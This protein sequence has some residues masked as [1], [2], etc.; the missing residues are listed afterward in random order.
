MVFP[1]MVVPSVYTF[2]DTYGLIPPPRAGATVFFVFAPCVVMVFMSSLAVLP[3]VWTSSPL[4]L[5]VSGTLSMSSLT[6]AVLVPAPVLCILCVSLSKVL[7]IFYGESGVNGALARS[8]AV[9][10][11]G[12]SKV[13][14]KVFSWGPPPIVYRVTH[15]FALSDGSD[16]NFAWVLIKIGEASPVSL[17]PDS[18]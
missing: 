3:V 2:V 11:P 1:S 18:S 6:A 4:T 5:E 8:F 14:L 12:P 15:A 16:A 13:L 9:S 10:T 7:P 17:P